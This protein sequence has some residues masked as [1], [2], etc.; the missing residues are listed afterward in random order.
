M[1]YKVETS[2]ELFSRPR[3]KLEMTGFRMSSYENQ[4]RRRLRILVR[5][6]RVQL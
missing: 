3:P 1:K 6:S 2:V 4:R 5:N